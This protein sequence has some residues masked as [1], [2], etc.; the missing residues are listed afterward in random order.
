MIQL[1]DTGADFGEGQRRVGLTDRREH[2]RAETGDGGSGQD[3]EGV[4]RTAVAAVQ[5]HGF[6]FFRA[7]YRVS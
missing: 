1:V 5:G 2:H 4:T 3:D 6:P 7:A